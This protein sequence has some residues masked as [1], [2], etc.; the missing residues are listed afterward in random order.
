MRCVY[1]YFLS[2]PAELWIILSLTE[3][4]C[5]GVQGGGYEPWTLGLYVGKLAV[6]R[7]VTRALGLISLHVAPAC[8][9]ITVHM[10]MTA[11]SCHFGLLSRVQRTLDL[12]MC[13]PHCGLLRLGRIDVMIST[14]ASVKTRVPSLDVD[15]VWHRPCSNF[16]SELWILHYRCCPTTLS[17]K[18][19]DL[20]RRSALR[21]PLPLRPDKLS[22][23]PSEPLKEHSR[24]TSPSSLGTGWK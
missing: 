9:R 18:A 13:K 8:V 10:N 17:G 20:A 16:G 4:L 6:G 15:L 24:Y 3:R 7:Y 5:H 1:H 22:I 2:I 19:P 21:S 11:W 14:R 12:R 23:Q